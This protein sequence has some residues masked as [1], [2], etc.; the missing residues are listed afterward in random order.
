[1]DKSESE[2]AKRIFFFNFRTV[3]ESKA[4]SSC[5]T[6]MFRNGK[7]K[8]AILIPQV[9]E[10]TCCRWRKFVKNKVAEFNQSKQ[11]EMDAKSGAQQAET[12]AAIFYNY[13][14]NV[15]ACRYCLQLLSP[16]GTYTIARAQKN[17]S[18]LPIKERAC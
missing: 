7:C 18:T 1:M 11:S 4:V 12:P 10:Q 14:N 13:A 2:V 5:L 16:Y 15:L 3:R 8:A 9:G 6:N 17:I